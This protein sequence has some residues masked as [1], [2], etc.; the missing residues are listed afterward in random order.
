MKKLFLVFMTALAFPCLWAADDF[1]YDNVVTETRFTHGTGFRFGFENIR[2]TVDVAELMY[3]HDPG[4]PQGM[5]YYHE[6]SWTVRFMNP[7]LTWQA[8]WKYFMLDIAPGW[9]FWTGDR[10]QMDGPGFSVQP[11]ARYALVDNQKLRYTVL[12]GPNFLIDIDGIDISAGL[13]QELG[14][15]INDRFMPFLGFGLGLGFG[16]GDVVYDVV[17]ESYG[18]D[19]IGTGSPEI[20]FQFTLGL[21]TMILEDVFYYR[22]REVHRRR[23]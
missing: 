15:K 19:N 20:R 1:V 11:M 4:W 5:W 23:R 21:K 13:T 18:S 9:T 3:I 8:E 6:E 16:M 22:G 17:R 14:L 2:G 12:L 10:S 7:G